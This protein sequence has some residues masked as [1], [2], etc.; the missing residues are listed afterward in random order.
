MEKYVKGFREKIKPHTDE[1]GN[2]IVEPFR[3][4]QRAL[5]RGQFSVR[6]REE[7]FGEC[8]QDILVQLFEKWLT[9]ETHAVK[10]REFLYHSALALG[11][12]KAMML[13]YEQFGTNAEYI[14]SQKKVLEAQKG[15][16]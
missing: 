12:V 4:A 6:E 14:E 9:S 2:A 1:K 13:Q 16:K 11:S 3:D 8:F 5:V 15:T 7:F 10:E